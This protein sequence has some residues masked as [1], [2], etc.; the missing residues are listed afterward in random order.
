MGRVRAEPEGRTSLKTGGLNT[1]RSSGCRRKSCGPRRVATRPLDGLT[2]SRLSA[3]PRPYRPNCPIGKLTGPKPDSRI[4]DGSVRGFTPGFFRFLA[5]SADGPGRSQIPAG[6][7]LHLRDTET[8]R[9][10]S[11]EG[12]EGLVPSDRVETTPVPESARS[13]QARSGS[14]SRCLPGE[15]P[16]PAR[17]PLRTRRLDHHPRASARSG[18]SR[19]RPDRAGESRTGVPRPFRKEW[20]PSAWRGAIRRASSHRPIHRL[21]RSG[22]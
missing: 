20:A 1:A 6:Q 22:P 7:V 21:A 8:W 9:R 4:V 17:R 5:K 12:R 3:P 11:A 10:S 15:S 2:R 19:P 13:R 14:A 18:R 16:G